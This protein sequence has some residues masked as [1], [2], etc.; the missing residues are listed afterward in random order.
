MFFLR[1]NLKNGVGDVLFCPLVII[2]NLE[3]DFFDAAR[4]AVAVAEIAGLVIGAE[5][6]EWSRVHGRLHRLLAVG[7]VRVLLLAPHGSGAVSVATA[8]AAVRISGERVIADV[9]AVVAVRRVESVGRTG[10]WASFEEGADIVR[11]RV[12]VVIDHFAKRSL[13]RRGAVSSSASAID[14]VR[15]LLLLM[16]DNVA[17]RQCHCLVHCRHQNGLGVSGLFLRKQFRV[18]LQSEN[19]H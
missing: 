6:P 19:G 9:V 4:G 14:S 10:R 7:R 12:T 13:G 15:L 3:V 1:R 5:R 17:R 16:L 8:E 11:R 2:I 18:L